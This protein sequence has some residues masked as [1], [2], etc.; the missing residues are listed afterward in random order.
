MGK[1]LDLR[2]Q[3]FGRLVVIEEAGRS[4]HGFVLWRCVC[5]CGNEVIVSSNCLR[6][7]QTQSCGCYQR[8]RSSEFAARCFATHGMCKTRLYRIWGS[9]LQRTGIHKGADEQSKRKYQDR[10]ITVCDE[11]LVFEN[12][13]DWAL[14]HGYCDDLQIDRIDND[15]GYSPENCRWVTP[16]ENANNRRCTIRLDDGTS[17]ALFCFKVGIGTYENGSTS[18][19]YHRIKY[20]YRKHHRPHPE[21]VKA[22]NQTILVM[23][24]CLEML[25]LLD[26]IKA[27]KA[28]YLIQ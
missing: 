1:K 19:L 25:K 10:G 28:Q 21:L 22:A 24:Q 27:F 18:R 9:M 23:R 7:G 16:R 11:W 3:M 6:T 20:M 2:G 15:K 8:E 5:D 17:L 4:K 14:S 26:D 13:R 12:F